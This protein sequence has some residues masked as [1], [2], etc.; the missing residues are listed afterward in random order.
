[1]NTIYII[2]FFILG[3]VMGSFYTVVG[4]RLP[5]HE[6]FIN[7]HSH[8]DS[9]GHTLSLYEMIPILSFLFQ[10]GRCR[11]CHKKIDAL[12]TYMELFTG[13]LFAVSFYSFSFSYE[14]LIALGITSMLIIIAVSDLTYLV[15]PDEILIFFSIYFIIINILNSGLYKAILSIGN[16]LLLFLIMYLIMLF[17][18]KI[19]KRESLGGGDIKMMFVFGLVLDPLLG[20]LSIF[21]GSLI[22]LPVS[23]LLLLKNKEKVIPFGPFLLIAINLIYFTK[24]TSEAIIKLITF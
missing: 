24:V 2:I 11:H 22:A 18:N 5:K 1:M 16:G 4:L 12:S 15:I 20:V 10:R 21:L 9:C 19:L 23:F 8:C 17:G 14:L 6:N 7:S 13:I 3:T